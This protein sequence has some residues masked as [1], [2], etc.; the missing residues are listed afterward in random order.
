MKRTLKLLFAQRNIE[1]EGGEERA[2]GKEGFEDSVQKISTFY[3]YCFYEVIRH[4]M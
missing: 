3:T 4:A 2:G 1:S